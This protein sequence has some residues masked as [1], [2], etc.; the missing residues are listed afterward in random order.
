MTDLLEA[1]LDQLLAEAAAVRD[2]VYGTRVTYSPKGIRYDYGPQSVEVVIGL[3]GKPRVVYTQES[4]LCASCACPRTSILRA[5]RV[6]LARPGSA[7][8]GH[9]ARSVPPASFL[10]IYWS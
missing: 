6:F 7:K 8:Y 10:T 4:R 2:R 3:C 5:P 9:R 1:P